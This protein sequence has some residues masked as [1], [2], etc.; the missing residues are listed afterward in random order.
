MAN[1]GSI[2]ALDVD[3][4][5]VR[6]LVVALGVREAARQ[7]GL[8]ED[9]VSTWSARGKWL[10][11]TPLPPTMAPQATK[12]IAPAEALTKALAEDSL[13]TKIGFSR[14]AVKVATHL[15]EKEPGDLIER[16][17]AQSA[18]QWSEIAG[19]VHGWDAKQDGAGV[20]V[21]VN[22]GIIGG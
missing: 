4:E 2:P 7:M 11:P 17:T 18:R 16:D 1:G 5:A 21:A 8:S 6:T 9:T 10:Q 13:N 20:N 15:G 12:A 19:K 22:I 14:A 3:R